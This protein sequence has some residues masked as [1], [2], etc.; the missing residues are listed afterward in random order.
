MVNN[1]NEDD[2]GVADVAET[3]TSMALAAARATLVV[4]AWESP[5]FL[6][7]AIKQPREALAAEG[8]DVPAGV[9]VSI[10]ADSASG[11]NV[12]LAVGASVEDAMDAVRFGTE[13]GIPVHVLQNTDKRLYLRVPP[14][15]AEIND[16]IIASY[17]LTGA[18]TDQATDWF[19]TSG[20]IIAVHDAIAAT[21]ALAAAEVAALALAIA[22]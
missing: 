5:E 1:M 13:H 9:D 8:F 11:I 17:N 18:P 3:T 14:A 12:I 10:V 2:I 16:E 7:K 4:K 20:N 22:T 15:P 19:W 21:E 6:A